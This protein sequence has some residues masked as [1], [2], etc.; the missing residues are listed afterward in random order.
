MTKEI[1]LPAGVE[2]PKL[3]D[4]DIIDNEVLRGEAVFWMDAF[5]GDENKLLDWMRPRACAEL[6]DV[7]AV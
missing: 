1:E 2:L 5:L 3:L 4:G 7:D 6:L